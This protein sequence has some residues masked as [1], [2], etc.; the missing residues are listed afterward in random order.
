[1]GSVFQEA[2]ELPSD[3]SQGNRQH[4]GG[5]DAAQGGQLVEVIRA[6]RHGA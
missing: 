3:E 6:S 1:M 2:A 4:D 5:D